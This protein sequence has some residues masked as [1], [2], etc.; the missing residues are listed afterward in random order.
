MVVAGVAVAVLSHGDLSRDGM[1]ISSRGTER[2]DPDGRVGLCPWRTPDEDRA[3]WFSSSTGYRDETLILSRH[4]LE[5]K[6]RLGRS[7]GPNDAAMIVHRILGPTSSFGMVITR[8]VRGECGL[9]ELVIAADAHGKVIGA[10]IQRQREPEW[11][12]RVIESKAWLGSF[13]GNDSC[14][15]WTLGDDI[16]TVTKSAE[17]SAQAILS[18]AKT[19]LI[20]LDVALKTEPGI[21][22]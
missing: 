14:S 8:R 22:K 7:P 3:L 16:P 12:S 18:E 19:V 11:T 13:V 15:H 5:L 1:E 20:L 4:L 17:A 2:R 21:R 9:I 10:R 6:R